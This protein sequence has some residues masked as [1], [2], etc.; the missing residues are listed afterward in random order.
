MVLQ[1]AIAISSSLAIVALTV[2][3]FLSNIARDSRG[4]ER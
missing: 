3:M 2:G 1:S 4:A